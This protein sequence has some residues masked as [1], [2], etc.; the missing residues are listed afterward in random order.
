[1]QRSTIL[2]AVTVLAVVVGIGL[3]IGWLATRDTTPPPPPPVPA[4][5]P[6]ATETS[7]TV[8]RI[9]RPSGRPPV[10]RPAVTDPGH[11]VPVGAP[12]I[13]PAPLGSATVITNWED[14]LDE[15]L[16][17]DEEDTNKVKQLLSMF[18]RLP[19]EGQDEVAQHLA[20]LV[21][22]EDYNPLLALVLD[23]KLPEGV[24]DSLLADLLNRPNQTKLPAFLDIAF[25]PDHPKAAEARDLLELY[26][27]QDL[28]TD[29]EAWRKKIDEW[30]KDNP[31]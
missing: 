20:N 4:S 30:L 27:D 18:P 13:S 7:T 8:P 15:I 29:R 14:R 21:E 11:A 12:A 5:A 23:P 10:S 16:S 22:D 26:L 25:M 6:V 2:T 19:A 28:G 3:G 9:A 31:D 24:L 1:M 17:N